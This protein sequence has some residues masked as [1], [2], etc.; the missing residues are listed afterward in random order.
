M[1]FSGA[2]ALLLFLIIESV[3]LTDLGDFLFGRLMGASNEVVRQARIAS[4]IMAIWVFPIF[5]RNIFYALAML[6]QKT[7]LITISTSIRLVS[8]FIFLFIYSFWLDTAAVGA[9]AMVS[10][11]VL[12]ALFMVI[13]SA[14]KIRMMDK[15][16]QT[17]SS[18]KDM[19]RFSWPLMITQ[20]TENGVGLTINFFL[21]R[22]ANPDLALA[23]FGVVL[24][25]LRT[26]LSP[27]RNV[28]QTA[29][30]L[31]KSRQD[32]RIMILFATL[33]V[34]VFCAL[35]LVTF[36]TPLRPIILVN[37][38]GLT[39]EIIMYTSSGFQMMFIVAV[40][41]G[42]AALFRGILSA[43]RLTGAIAFTAILRLVVVV[44]I[45]SS[46]LFYSQLNGSVIGVLAISISFAV[47]TVVL[48]V[49]LRHRLQAAK[50]LFGHLEPPRVYRRP[51]SWEN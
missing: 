38:M 15:S 24:G 13:I 11:M 6:N 32:L 4:A 21:G 20:V 14:P 39:E 29:Q 5:I 22:L 43:M 31:I 2:I 37:V 35:V 50:P 48:W 16:K 28:V 23:G 12:E 17:Y 8:L 7:I 34:V 19:W 26:L 18:Y 25:I 46:A 1:R 3:A 44:I 51:H 27:L 30:A 33:T 41:W 49:R 9:L 36:N 10:C 45:G 42:Y 47:E 40:F